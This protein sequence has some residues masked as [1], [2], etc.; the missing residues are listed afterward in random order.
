M[1]IISQSMLR[2]FSAMH[3][4]A[5]SR[6]NS[7]FRTLEKSSPRDFND[8]KRIFPS[9]DYVPKKYSVFD[10]GGNA[11]RVVVA[12]HYNTQRAYIRGVF[13]HSQYDK[14]TRDNRTK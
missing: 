6:L 10:V 2:R 7:W 14:W 5:E 3:P 8:L 12:I 13:T 9:V 4:E 1:H 11:Y